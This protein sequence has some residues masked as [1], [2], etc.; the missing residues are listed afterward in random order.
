M[1]RKSILPGKYGGFAQ[2]SELPKKY[3]DVKAIKVNNP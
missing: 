1:K 3:M 2:Y